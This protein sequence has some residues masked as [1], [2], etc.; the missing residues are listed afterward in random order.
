[1][2]LNFF[3]RYRTENSHHV[4]R[5]PRTSLTTKSVQNPHMPLANARR[6]LSAPRAKHDRV[7]PPDA[8]VY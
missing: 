3:E 8:S 2:L 1:M 6:N 4:T 5:H 7:Y